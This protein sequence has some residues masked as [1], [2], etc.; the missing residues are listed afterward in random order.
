MDRKIIVTYTLDML[1]TSVRLQWW[2]LIGISGFA[3]LAVLI[4]AFAYL[5]MMGDRSWMFGFSLALL[6]IWAGLIVGSYFRLLR[7]SM[8]KFRKMQDP[9]ATFRFTSEGVSIVADTGRVDFVWGLL[10]KVIQS[11]T[12]W[13]LVA[14]GGGVSLPTQALDDELKAFILSKPLEKVRSV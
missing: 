5:A 1:R 14:A 13:V 12:L 11:E 4:A 8:S 10:T 7:I 6:I 3:L 9:T 2:N